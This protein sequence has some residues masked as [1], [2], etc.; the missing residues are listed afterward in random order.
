MKCV[1]EP[2]VQSEFGM[3]Q[4]PL[5]IIRIRFFGNHGPM[6][7]SPSLSCDQRLHAPEGRSGPFP[8][9]VTPHLCL[10]LH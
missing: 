8:H 7:P 6:S 3:I 1:P 10:Q 4:L 2:I 5:I 9:Q